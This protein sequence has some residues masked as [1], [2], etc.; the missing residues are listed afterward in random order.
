MSKWVEGGAVGFVVVLPALA[1]HPT[2][3]A[4]NTLIAV[5]H[6]EKLI[7]IVMLLLGEGGL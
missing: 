1:P 4:V 2:T 6:V 3:L 7:G 5:G